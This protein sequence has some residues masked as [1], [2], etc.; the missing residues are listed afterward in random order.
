M[1]RVLPVLT[2]IYLAAPPPCV[3][4]G[5]GCY[6]VSGAITSVAHQ[7]TC[8]HSVCCESQC[9]A[10]GGLWTDGCSSCECDITDCGATAHTFIDPGHPQTLQSFGCYDI[11]THVCSDQPAVN[12]EQ[13]CWA[14]GE[15]FYWTKHCS[16][17]GPTHSERSVCPFVQS[18]LAATVSIGLDIATV[19][20]PGSVTRT[21][22][23]TNVSADLA[24]LVN[25]SAHRVTI[26]SL[27]G[28]SVITNFRITAPGSDFSTI[29]ESHF[30]NGNKV[31]GGATATGFALVSSGSSGPTPTVMVS[32]VCECCYQ[33]SVSALS[34]V[35]ECT[36][37]TYPT[38]NA[39]SLD[40]C[41][42]AQ[43]SSKFEECPDSGRHNEHSHVKATY[44]NCVCACCEPVTNT[45]SR[46]R[47]CDDYEYYTFTASTPDYCSDA[48]C[49]AMFSNCPDYGQHN[50][51]GVVAA[52]YLP[53]RYFT[54]ASAA[55][56]TRCKCT[57]CMPNHGVTAQC[58][59]M[60]DRYLYT[61]SAAHCSPAQCSGTFS[62]CPDSGTHNA[63]GVVRAS[64]HDCVCA[65]CNDANNCTVPHY[66]TFTAHYAQACSEYECSTRFA[67][68]C[69]SQPSATQVV[70]ALFLT[71]PL[72]PA[73]PA[74]ESNAA[75]PTVRQPPAKED[76]SSSYIV[77]VLI[78]MVTIPFAIGMGFMLYR[79]SRDGGKVVS[80]GSVNDVHASRNWHSVSSDRQGK[81]APSTSPFEVTGSSG[82]VM[83]QREAGAP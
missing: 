31:L 4:S 8:A 77:I 49:A 15:H 33:E 82:A 50:D 51:G 30:A 14:A 9:E 69:P 24:D 83:V 1:P 35:S 68:Q 64:Y 7:C 38:F 19:G 2:L 25:T 52:M 20:G 76:G 40:H 36:D 13:K 58:T 57:C 71:A 74:V 63:H 75:A 29:L 65:C 53:T 55:V 34:S 45:H 72:A 73:L 41:T 37:Y 47:L 32:C 27:A 80:C 39:Q 67:S 23:M 3:R 61:E 22:F 10:Q 44:H 28:G 26:T 78:L 43:C 17:D 16:D 59:D 62:Q 21:G 66:F 60:V 54:D 12:C 46:E 79:N 81:G 11:R 48:N 42:A 6:D 56:L 18:D 5:F 70:K